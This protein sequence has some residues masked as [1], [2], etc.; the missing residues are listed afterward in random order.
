[1][2]VRYE[3]VVI[4]PATPGV[5]KAG[6]DVLNTSRT[7]WKRAEGFSF[8]YHVFDAQT[9][10]LIVDGER[11]A[12]PADWS[13]GEGGHL[14]IDVQLPAADGD[15]RVYLSPLKEN[16]AWLYEKGWRFLAFD[17]AVR[18]GTVSKGPVRIT[19]SAAVRI[20]RAARSFVRAF[21]LP[22]RS[23]LTNRRLIYSMTRRDILSRYRGSYMGTFWTVLSPLL[24]MVTYFFVFGVVLRT[25]FGDDPSH[26]GFALYFL[27]GMLPWLPFAEAVGRAPVVMLEHR[28]FV[29]KM[30]FPVEIF[31]VN[32]TAAGLATEAVALVLFL[33]A[34]WIF[35]AEIP[36]SAVWLPALIVPQLLF[37]LGL[38][39]FL[40]ALG[41]YMRDL[42]QISGFLL[43]LWF[44]LTPIC[45][46]ESSLP[47]GARLI[48][49][50]NPLYPLVG[51]YRAI[52]LEGQAPNLAALGKLWLL[53][54][55]VFLIGHAW[56]HK[57]RRTFADVI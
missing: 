22:I 5:L 21:V 6:F 9:E 27:A 42:G 10:T 20:R 40:A 17:V 34:L 39:W 24:L 54:A 18:N 53:G 55:A 43:T 16:V 29:K 51:A 50:K 8:G 57:L 3:H 25:R 11:T 47:E 38:C 30:L 44:F 2:S 48:L 52:L 45:Y 41:V 12:L 13:P 36:A 28:N 31:P 56:F 49:A 33:A 4:A 15:Y 32:L 7:P 1:M 19:T 35:R 14:E 23:I 46:P 37:T 26:S